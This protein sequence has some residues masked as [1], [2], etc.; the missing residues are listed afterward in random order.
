LYHLHLLANGAGRP[1]ISR[2][3]VNLQPIW[4]ILVRMKLRVSAHSKCQ[5]PVAA[6]RLYDAVTVPHPSVPQEMFEA[7]SD[8]ARSDKVDSGNV[9]ARFW[10]G[11]RHWT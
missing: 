8:K 5:D 10:T 6:K 7:V 2:Q 4:E 11:S 9:Q 1:F 3:C